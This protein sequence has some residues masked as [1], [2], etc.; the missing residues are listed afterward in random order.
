MTVNASSQDDSR[1][2]SLLVMDLGHIAFRRNETTVRPPAGAEHSADPPRG[3][4]TPAPPPAAASLRPDPPR[5]HAASEAVVSGSGT[6]GNRPLV[7]AAGGSRGSA[8][9][10]DW[11]L[12]VTGVQVRRDTGGCFFFCVLPLLSDLLLFSFFFFFFPI[13]SVAPV[14]EWCRPTPSLSKLTGW[15]SLVDFLTYSASRGFE[16]GR[17]GRVLLPRSGGIIIPSAPRR[18]RHHRGL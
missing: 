15:F 4:S 6:L 10:D 3:G 7:V 16:G 18:Y 13:A 9:T 14:S 1:S 2:K 8:K 12:D 5:I 11:R 17:G